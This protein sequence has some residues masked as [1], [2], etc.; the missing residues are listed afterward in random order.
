MRKT[1]SMQPYGVHSLGTTTLYTARFGLVRKHF[2]RNFDLALRD[3]GIPTLSNV[4]SR[5]HTQ[6]KFASF[7]S[8]CML[9][10][11]LKVEGPKK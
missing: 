7:R 5:A 11:E 8:V 4:A 1:I 6:Q 2:E 10:S 3:Y 9:L